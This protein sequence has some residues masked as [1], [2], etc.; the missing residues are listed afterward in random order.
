MLP[1]ERA[2]LKTE[3]L[4]KRKEQNIH[5]QRDL[6]EVTIKSAVVTTI[7]CMLMKDSVLCLQKKGIFPFLRIC[8][9][10]PKGS[11]GSSDSVLVILSGIIFSITFVFV[12]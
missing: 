12:I 4:L 9:S 8:S 6:P 2:K 10:L 3:L 5:K 11:V 7:K 1:V